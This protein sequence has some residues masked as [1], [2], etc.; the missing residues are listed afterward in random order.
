MVS[1][2]FLDVDGVLNDHSR[3]PVNGYCGIIPR[4]MEELNRV[5]AR[6]ECRIILV[7]AWRYMIL[8]GSMTLGGFFNMMRTHGMT[9]TTNPFID[10]AP[11]D[12]DVND[13]L[14][15][16]RAARTCLAGYRNV[17]SFCAIDDMEL[18]YAAAGIPLVHTDGSVGLT[19][20]DADHAIAILLGRC[21]RRDVNS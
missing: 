6:T 3:H 21:A 18:G 7:S 2:L 12:V 8:T 20:A 14:E 10:F 16:G 11:K 1:I 13:G 17:E 4:C 15:R 9:A 5:V 19:G